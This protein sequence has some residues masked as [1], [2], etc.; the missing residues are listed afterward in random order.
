MEKEDYDKAII[1]SL[2][3]MKSFMDEYDSNHIYIA[4]MQF[5]LG[6]AYAMMSQ[7]DSSRT[8]YERSLN[9]MK[10]HYTPEDEGYKRVVFI[11][12][13]LSKLDSAR[14]GITAL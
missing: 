5:N 8:Y 7:V 2:R 1:Y 9:G 14:V 12:Q 4:V 10:K 11:E 6:Q 3:A 13:Q